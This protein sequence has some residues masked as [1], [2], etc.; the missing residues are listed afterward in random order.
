MPE[1]EDGVPEVSNVLNARLKLIEGGVH[2]RPPLPETLVTAVDVVALNL[3]CEGVPL[4]L[5]VPDFQH[6]LDV[7]PVVALERVMEEPHVLLR[8][9]LP[10][11]SRGAGWR[12]RERGG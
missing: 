2:V 3:R 11:I 4:G 6:R 8:H 7:A 10:S 9:R 12:R 5:G 1:C